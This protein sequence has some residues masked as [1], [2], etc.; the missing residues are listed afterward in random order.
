V[1]RPI[2]AFVG[3]LLMSTS[4]Q[5]AVVAGTNTHGGAK[6]GGQIIHV[7]SL[8]DSGPGTLRAAV[9]TSGPRVVVFDVAGTIPLGSDLKFSV[10]DVTV[11]GQ[12]APKPGITL[13]GASVRVRTHDVILQ[14]IAVRPG[15]GPTPQ[16]NGNRDSITIG[17]GTQPALDVR[18]EN[19]STTW[20]VDENIDVASATTHNVVVRN[21]LIAEALRNAGHPK[22]DHS[23]GMLINDGPQGVAIAG[24]LFVSN[25]FRNP[26]IARGSAAFVGYNDIVNPGMNSIHFYSEERNGPLRVSIIGNT[27]EAGLD[28]S[29]RVTAVQIPDDMATLS[30]DAQIYLSN[31]TAVPGPLTNNG[32]F[33]LATHPPVTYPM[34][35]I[36]DVHAWAFRYAG[37]RPHERDAVDTRIVSQAAAHTTHIIDNPSNVGGLPQITPVKAVANVPSDPFAPTNLDGLL[38]IEAWLCERHLEVGG[39]GTPQCRRGLTAYRNVLAQ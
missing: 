20:S 37:S 8:A 29:P 15:P 17:G 11:A 6:A 9:Q 16:I 22:G 18:V 21:S 28:T 35:A 32:G 12:T 38:R 4:A 34:N 27:I 5:A 31:N 13:T 36:A 19:V 10:P 1:G 24:N 2:P 7:T 25:Q 33:K 23:M 3:A 14:H 39:P 30:P 26:A